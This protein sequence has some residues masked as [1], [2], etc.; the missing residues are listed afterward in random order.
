MKVEEQKKARELRQQG[1][2]IKNIAKEL[3]VAKSSVSRW[4]YDIELTEEQ[5]H[6]LYHGLQIYKGTQA[7]KRKAKILREQSQKEG[8]LKAKEKNILHAM[9]CML[10]WAEG[11][12]GRNVVGIANSDVNMLKFFIKFLKECYSVSNENIVLRTNCYTDCG[13]TIE[14]IEQWW[15]KELNLPKT[16]LRK[17]TVNH[18]SKYSKNKRCGKLK[19]GTCILKICKTKLV[20]N[21]FGAI[22]EYGNFTNDRWLG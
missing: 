6:S 9:G 3:N 18:L 17:S 10:Y 22:Q 1:K 5:I 2:S 12:K 11:F 19:Y 16:C 4:V 20:Q 21:I 14:E 8:C 13:L 15:L 7:N